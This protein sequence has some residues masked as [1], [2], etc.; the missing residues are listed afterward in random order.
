MPPDETATGA[1][2]AETP[3]GSPPAAPSVPV[4]AP[5]PA[6]PAPAVE[7]ATPA[8]PAKEAA[9]EHAPTLLEA[10]DGKPKADA[11]DA[12]ASDAKPDEAAKESP[13]PAEAAKDAKSEGDKPKD[14][15]KK[16]DAAKAPDPA[17]EATAKEP[18]APVKYEAFKVP[19]GRKIDEE[20][21]SKLTE[22]T[23]SRH[24]PQEDTQKIVDLGFEIQN[25]MI[26]AA[27][28][29]QRDH[30]ASTMN[31]W[32]DQTRKDPELGGNDGRLK[33]S[34]GMAKAV[35]EEYSGSPERAQRILALVS[36]ETGN[37]LGN[38]P[39]FLHFLHNMGVKLNVFEDSIVPAN[40]AAPKMPKGNPGSGKTGWYDK[41]PGNGAAAS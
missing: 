29:E 16:D 10:A 21:V 17:K 3:S 35:I 31:T 37:G 8:E 18:P 24:L 5:E 19:E 14:E 22:I 1:P 2:V 36:Q 25:K 13:A 12:K 7:V 39:D 40:P 15:A 41:G 34:L 23:G 28:Q 20:I 38:N 32:K 11:K 27:R 4:A 6:A 30:W 9:K 33:K 26:E